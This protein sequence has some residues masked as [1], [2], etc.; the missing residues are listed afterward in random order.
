MKRIYLSIYVYFIFLCSPKNFGGAHSRR[1]VHL[2]VSP[3]VPNWCPAHNVAIGSRNLKVFY[4][5]DH[6]IETMCRTQYLGRYLEGQGHN[7]TLQQNH[8][9]PIT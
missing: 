2:S 9:W 6:H 1:V 7:M 3:Y 5:N 8:V 4:R